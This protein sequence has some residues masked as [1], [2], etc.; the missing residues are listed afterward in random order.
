M[1]EQQNAAIYADPDTPVI[2]VAAPGSGKTRVLTHRVAYLVNKQMVDPSSI[3]V[4]TFTRKATEEMQ[5]RLDPLIGSELD[6]LRIG[7]IHA[8]CLRLL[9]AEGH[10]DEVLRTFE[11]QRIMRDILGEKRLNYDIGWKYP[12]H[13]INR[14]KSAVIKPEDSE[15]FFLDILDR[16]GVTAK[17]KLA[18]QLS[19]CYSEYEND[20][21][22]EGKMDFTDML[23]RTALLFREQPE[24]LRKWQG[25][26]KYV[27]IDEG[28]DTSDLSY[29][30]LR[31]LAYPE[32]RLFIVGDPD[33]VLF[34]FTDAKPDDNIYGF[35]FYYPDGQV[36]PLETNYRSTINIVDKSNQIIE[37]NYH[38]APQ[39]VLDFKKKSA[40]RED[41]EV[42]VP[43]TVQECASVEDEA[44]Y[45]CESIQEMEG[46]DPQDIFVI[47]RVN[48]QSRAIEGELLKAKIPYIIQGSL[49]FYDRAE[50]KDLIAYMTL[51]SN[52]HDDDAFLRVC[53]I[54][55]ADFHRPTRGIGAKWKEKAGRIAEQNGWSLY[56]TMINL[57]PK[58]SNWYKKGL[59]DLHNL[60]LDIAEQAM[61]RPSSIL[62]YLRTKC[63]ESYILRNEGITPEEAQDSNLFENIEELAY[64]VSQFDTVDELL[65]H[66]NEL[67]E[68]QEQN[69][70]SDINAVVLTTIHKAKGLERPVVFGIGFSEGILPHALSLLP[71][72]SIGA[73]PIEKLTDIKDERCAAFVLV[74]R[75]QEELKLSYPISYRDAEV[76]PSRFLYEMELMNEEV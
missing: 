21:E 12:L 5:E 45:V 63:Y 15:D 44:A 41:A 10:A 8:S 33:Q 2:V 34:R 13:W 53:N 22:M 51:I 55:S 62:Y 38:N 4:C 37:H 48:A 70:T 61:D 39:H 72:A 59:T 36:L 43:V 16:M 26:I 68:L 75:A 46:R 9:K 32:N 76:L 65:A 69:K 57:I 11:Q 17:E 18:H 58:E 25:I 71:V 7:T 19:G 3:L 56:E 35:K 67:R 54:A 30:I 47:Y 20:K 31:Q 14:A 29:N 60:I 74:S 52:P 49:G 28:Q 6:T 64:A 50:V 40:P 23:Y 27:L 73:L 42:G 1:N 66:I 24:I